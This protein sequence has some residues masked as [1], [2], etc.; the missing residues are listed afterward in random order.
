MKKRKLKKIWPRNCGDLIFKQKKNKEKEIFGR[1]WI[2]GELKYKF[3]G[4]IKKIMKFIKKND[5][6]VATCFE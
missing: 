2:K 3:K 6:T 5:F 4:K 1:L